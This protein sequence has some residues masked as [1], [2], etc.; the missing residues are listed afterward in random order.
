V[1]VARPKLVLIVEMDA[2][3]AWQRFRVVPMD[4][5]STGTQVGPEGVCAAAVW[6]PDGNPEQI[7]FGPTEEE[8]LAAAPDGKSLIT[9]IGVRQSSVWTHDAAG[10]R[11]VSQEGSASASSLS[12]DGKRLYYLLQKNNQSDVQDLWQRDLVSGKSNPVLQGLRI[13]DLRSRGTKRRW[14]LR[15]LGR[16]AKGRSSS[17]RPIEARLRA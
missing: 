4:G 3:T 15:Q 2:A 6:S 12:A 11:M 13:L 8:G 5:K 1:A 10:D 16:E 9:S 7:T 14:R 17:R